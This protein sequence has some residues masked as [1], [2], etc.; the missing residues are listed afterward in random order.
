MRILIAGQT[1]GPQNGPGVFEQRLARGLAQRGDAVTVVVPARRLRSTAQRDEGV[2]IEEVRAVRLAPLYPEVSVTVGA[3]GPAR[4]IVE[5]FRPD[6]VH[7]HDHYPLS[8]AVA[9]AARANA[10]PVVATNHFLPQNLSS[11]MWVCRSGFVRNAFE[12]YAWRGLLDFLNCA[13]AVTT[14]TETAAAI[15]REHGLRAPLRA[16]SCGVDVERFVPATPDERRAL[17]AGRGLRDEAAIFVYAGRLDR[18]KRVETLIDAVRLAGDRDLQ[19]VVIGRGHDQERLRLRAL[20]LRS[21]VLFAGFVSDD[22]L[23]DILRC[24]DFFAM[25]GDAELQSIATLEA[26]ACG[27]PVL[28]ADALALREIVT[29]GV[30]GER[31]APRDPANA[32]AKM[33]ALVDARDRWP[34]MSAASRSVACGHAIGATVDAYAGLYSDLV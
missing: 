22:V 18:D 12:G 31:F 11:Q 17:R 27:L 10:I 2:A 1:F 33:S 15:L 7:L 8:K 16:I 19:L 25:P 32:A 34:A 5:S 29:P 24:A 13:K 6:V 9:A 3:R 26:M 14:P 28:A 21:R 4:R 20:D 30:N 23:R